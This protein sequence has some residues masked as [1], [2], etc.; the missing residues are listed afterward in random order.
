[1]SRYLLIPHRLTW[2]SLRE[3]QTYHISNT[4]IHIRSSPVVPDDYNLART[5]EVTPKAVLWTSEV[6]LDHK[7]FPKIPILFY[8][9]HFIYV[10]VLCSSYNGKYNAIQSFEVTHDFITI[11]S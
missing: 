8:D 7:I 2:S 10:R 5:A 1:M 6:L 11:L 3:Q 9:V 4:G